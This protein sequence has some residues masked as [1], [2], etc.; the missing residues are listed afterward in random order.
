MWTFRSGRS[1]V[2]LGDVR[3]VADDRVEEWDGDLEDARTAGRPARAAE[4]RARLRHA[5][6]PALRGVLDGRRGGAGG[7]DALRG[8]DGVVVHHGRVQTLG[9]GRD[10]R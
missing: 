6:V 2:E 1:V 3:E 5:R 4:G 9:R 8:R 7:E 10:R